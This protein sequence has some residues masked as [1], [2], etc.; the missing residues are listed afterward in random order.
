[1][2]IVSSSNAAN[3]TASSGNATLAAGNATGETGSPVEIVGPEQI[4]Q[5]GTNSAMNPES[6]CIICG[7]D[8][9]TK[10]VVVASCLHKFHPHCIQSWWRL[11]E[12]DPPRRDLQN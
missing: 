5:T 12:I 6:L 1:M 3:S 8:L 2:Q 7:S 9:G 10:R 4:N 11:A